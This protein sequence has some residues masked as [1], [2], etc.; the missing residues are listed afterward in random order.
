MTLAGVNACS[1][2]MRQLRVTKGVAE[3][4]AAADRT[5]DSCSRR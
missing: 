3:K 2:P 1:S 5:C 4:L